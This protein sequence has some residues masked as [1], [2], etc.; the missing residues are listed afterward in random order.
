MAAYKLSAA[1]DEDL[2]RLYRYGISNFGVTRADTYYNGLI[3]QFEQIASAPQLYQAVDDI[4][5]GYR[6][7]A[8]KAHGI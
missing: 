5:A 8:F 6:R 4:R 2:T 7:C 3:A 1:A